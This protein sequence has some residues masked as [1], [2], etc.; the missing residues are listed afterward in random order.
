VDLFSILKNAGIKP[1]VKPEAAAASAH[2]APQSP[3][4]ATAKA[5]SSPGLPGGID[6]PRTGDMVAGNEAV[7]V[8]PKSEAKEETGPA[9]AGGLVGEGPDLSSQIMSLL[10]KLKGS[11]AAE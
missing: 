11:G 2:G 4:R 7:K 6:G 9:A 1:A 8:K 10:S 5:G 3:A